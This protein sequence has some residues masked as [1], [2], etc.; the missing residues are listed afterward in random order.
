MAHL[1]FAAFDVDTR[2]IG[3]FK[4]DL[5]PAAA[6]PPASAIAALLLDSPCCNNRPPPNSAPAGLVS[7]P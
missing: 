7:E 1:A 2:F 6:T 3:R 5:L 4:A